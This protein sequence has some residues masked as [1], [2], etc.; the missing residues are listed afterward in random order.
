MHHRGQIGLWRNLMSLV[1]KFT[2]RFIFVCIFCWLCVWLLVPV[3]SIAWKVVSENN[4]IIIRRLITRAISEYMTE[5][6]IYYVSSGM[7]NPIRLE[8]VARIGWIWQSHRGNGRLLACFRAGRR[9]L[10]LPVA[11][12]TAPC[13]WLFCRNLVA[14]TLRRYSVTPLATDMSHCGLLAALTIILYGAHATFL[15]DSV[16]LISACSSSSVVPPKTV[17]LETVPKTT[18]ACWCFDTNQVSNFFKRAF[19]RAM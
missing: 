12:S 15:C 4:I 7:S 10:W 11:I 18:L 9:R 14:E 5:S 16:T 19:S 6:V 17:L 2:F 13:F 1:L 3:T 8:N